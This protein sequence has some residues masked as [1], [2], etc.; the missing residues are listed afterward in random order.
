MECAVRS[1]GVLLELLVL[2]GRAQSCRGGCCSSQ[3]TAHWAA[4]VWDARH[5]VA[6]MLPAVALARS[7]LP[8]GADVCSWRSY[9]TPAAIQAAAAL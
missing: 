9:Q 7:V 8:V 6:F 5:A 3:V 1:W 2:A 4:I